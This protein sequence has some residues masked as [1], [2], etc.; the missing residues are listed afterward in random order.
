VGADDKLIA[1]LLRRTSFG[2]L[3]GQVAALSSGGISAAIDKVLAAPPIKYT[4]HATGS[5]DGIQKN[6]LERMANPKA[7]LHEK[8]VW[9]WHGH[10]TSAE[11]KVNNP[12]YMATQHNLFRANALGNF[13]ELA[14]NATIDPAMLIYLDGDGSTIDAPNENYAREAQELFTIGQPNVTQANVKNAAK[15]L[16][17]WTAHK[18][19]STFDPTAGNSST[20]PL[21]FGGN[22]VM[23]TNARD[24]TDALCSHPACAPFIV[25]KLYGYLAGVT[26]DTATLNNLVSVFTG[27]NLEIRPLVEAIIRDPAFLNMRNNRPRYPV[28]WLAAARVVSGVKKPYPVKNA[29]DNMGQIPFDPPSVAGWGP[30]TRW[31]SAS[32][33]LAKAAFLEGTKT[34]KDVSSAA[35]P[36]AATLQRCS[37]YEVSTE[38]TD[39]LQGFASSVSNSKLRAIGLVA[40]ALASPEFALA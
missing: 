26:P 32:V 4:A 28:E 12:G 3:P 23:V 11:S 2:P 37:L 5:I 19:G 33:V 8:M 38:T 22:T 10:F 29:V 18:Q 27:G 31:L 6:W 34:M 13:R 1:H 39:A 9:F 36:V 7:G 17:G 15:A 40:L 24:V 25:K 35:D 21:V 30:G 16:S 14:Y 20:L